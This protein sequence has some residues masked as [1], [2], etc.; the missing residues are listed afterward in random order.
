MSVP[1]LSF[2]HGF[3][4]TSRINEQARKARHDTQSQRGALQLV[5]L[6]FTLK[7]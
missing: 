6:W 2:L 1:P 3:I 4:K 7:T 5:S